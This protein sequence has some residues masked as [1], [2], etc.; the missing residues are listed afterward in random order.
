MKRPMAISIEDALGTAIGAA[1]AK[2]QSAVVTIIS[3]HPEKNGY[4]A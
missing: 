1:K 3:E 2:A 4:W